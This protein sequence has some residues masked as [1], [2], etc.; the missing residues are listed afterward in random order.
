M[1][2]CDECGKVIERGMEEWDFT[3]DGY[4]FVY[5]EFCFY[6]WIDFHEVT[7]EDIEN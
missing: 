2:R 1:Y 4:P 5:C 7:L 3:E 6:E